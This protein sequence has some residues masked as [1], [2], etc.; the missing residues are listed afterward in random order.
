MKAIFLFLG[1]KRPLLNIKVQYYTHFEEWN[2]R[3]SSIPLGGILYMQ[4]ESAASDTLLE[5][6]IN[7]MNYE[8]YPRGYPMDK[9][10]IIFY[11]ENGDVLK[12]WEFNDG[13]LQLVKTK[14]E[15]NGEKSNDYFFRN[16]SSNSRIWTFTCKILEY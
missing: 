3:P 5:E 4:L 7:T 11:D 1:E 2:G 8:L 6:R 13:I 16:F 10:E 15:V 14:L 12:R 9:G